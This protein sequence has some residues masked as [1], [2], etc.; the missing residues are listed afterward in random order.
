MSSCSDD[1]RHK[2]HD[3]GR[4]KAVRRGPTCTNRQPK[5]QDNPADVLLLTSSNEVKGFAPT[6]L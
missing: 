4:R 6:Q 2:T 1:V 3:A 5:L